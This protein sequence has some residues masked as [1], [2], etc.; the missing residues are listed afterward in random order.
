MHIFFKFPRPVQQ[1]LKFQSPLVPI[2]YKSG[3][4]G[5]EPDPKPY[6]QTLTHNSALCDRC[7]TRIKGEW[8]RCAYCALD[9]CDSC[10]AV[11]TH[12]E[13]HVFMVLKAEVDMDI[14]KIFAQLDHHGN[15]VRSKPVIPYPVYH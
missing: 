1:Q 12:D 9:L 10:E 5:S 7:M 11:D 2:L 8:F 3:P 14:F 15:G 13:T 6:L 4:G